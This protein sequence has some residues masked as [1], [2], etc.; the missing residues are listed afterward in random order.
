MIE[1]LLALLAI[2][3]ILFW[4]VRHPIKS[5]KFIFSIMGLMIL[6][7]TRYTPLYSICYRGTNDIRINNNNF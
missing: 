3:F 7:V 2:G 1:T 5:T 6:G 4:L